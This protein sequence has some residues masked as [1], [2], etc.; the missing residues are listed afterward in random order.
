[1]SIATSA[2]RPLGLSYADLSARVP[3]QAAPA[4]PSLPAAAPSLPVSTLALST[5]AGPV[6][7]SYTLDDLEANPEL[8]PPSGEP[9]PTGGGQAVTLRNGA[10]GQAVTA[11]QQALRA[12]GFE[13][14]STD[15]KFGPMT[16]RA[17]K[18]FQGAKG[19]KVDGVAGPAVRRALG[20]AE[21]APVGETNTGVMGRLR[22]HL[23]GRF[24]QARHKCFSYAWN[25]VAR[26]GGKGIGGASQSHAGRGRGVAALE[27]L[28][29][30]GQVRPGDVIYVNKAPGA[31]P[32]SRNLRYGPHWFV[33]MGNGRYADQYG[34][35]SAA[36]MAAFVPGRKIDAIYH[37]FA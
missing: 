32:S 24:W 5:T 11:L 22:A 3:A 12:A 20:L 36:A 9:E 26:A 34:E 30:S 21:T 16:E 1:M 23:H 13:P 6:A 2:I 7:G 35:R 15:G 18:R 28:E 33:Y 8:M 10:S 37:S 14:G 17:L 29:A 19:L 27:Q 4:A 25:L 31:D